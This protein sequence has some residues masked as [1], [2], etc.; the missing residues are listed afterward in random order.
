MLQTFVI[1]IENH[2]LAFERVVSV[3]RRRAFEIRS[4][5]AALGERELP[6]SYFPSKRTS[7]MP[8]GWKTICGRF[9]M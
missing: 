1:E 5:F 7:A 8:S 2:T 4:A 6:A 3:V 9:R